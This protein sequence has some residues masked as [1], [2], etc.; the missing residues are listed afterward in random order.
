MIS[1]ETTN[2]ASSDSLTQ[3]AKD[4]LPC[5]IS[6]A[7]CSVSAQHG[8]TGRTNLILMLGTPHVT[9]TGRKAHR[10]RR[11]WLAQRAPW[12]FDAVAPALSSGIPR[13][14]LLQSTN[15]HYH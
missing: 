7:A 10:S 1:P 14:K 13:S 4:L 15:S 8:Q 2:I 9:D 5:D 11:H 3:P 6:R 12:A